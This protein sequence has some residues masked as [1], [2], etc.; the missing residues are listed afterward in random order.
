MKIFMAIN[1]F[2]EP[3]RAALEARKEMGIDD[4]YSPFQR[5]VQS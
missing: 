5:Q 4:A 2:I 1:K 3:E